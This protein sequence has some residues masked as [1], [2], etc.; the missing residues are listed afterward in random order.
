MSN[1]H[2]STSQWNKKQ[3]EEEAARANATGWATNWQDIQGGFNPDVF[4]NL[5]DVT[6]QKLTDYQIGPPV[7]YGEG[8][9]VV[10]TF[11]AGHWSDGGDWG[12]LNNQSSNETVYGDTFHHGTNRGSVQD[13][14]WEM[15]LP[16]IE[17]PEHLTQF[18]DRTDALTAKHGNFLEDGWDAK[19]ILLYREAPQQAVATADPVVDT[20][21]ATA[22]DVPEVVEQEPVPKEPT[23][24]VDY[25]SSEMQDTYDR[26]QD[27]NN[28]QIQDQNY[29]TSF[30]ADEWIAETSKSD[31][32]K[33]EHAQKLADTYKFKINE[34]LKE[35]EK[36]DKVSTAVGNTLGVFSGYSV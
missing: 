9:P 16:N 22:V 12:T 27:Y 4:Q 29:H 32:D 26:I 3:E 17:T 10:S 14:V 20:P 1:H 11:I 36:A 19:D 15:G 28:D 30:N 21:V 24:G 8:D 7:L 35:E 33:Q 13:A 25:M 23:E 18:L 2:M 34:Q 31:I 6:R 5:D